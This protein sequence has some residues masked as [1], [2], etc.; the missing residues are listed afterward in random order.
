LTEQDPKQA[1][2][3]DKEA[4]AQPTAPEDSARAD[5]SLDTLLDEY[6]RSVR[7]QTP[8]EIPQQAQ[9]EQAGDPRIARI[10][11]RL[12]QEDVDTAVTNILGD[13]SIPRRAAIGWL[14]QVARERPLVARAFFNKSSDPQTWKKMERSLSHEL[15]KEFKSVMQSRDDVNANVDREA[16]AASLR[17]ASTKVT[18]EPP[19]KFG[20]M[21]NSEF[22]KKVREEY[23]FDPGV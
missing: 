1:V 5:Q 6:D 7:A 22:R 18:A 4:V 9:P 14:D 19:P 13:L 11:Q 23:G 16:V 21:S 2:V 20:N 8:P 15:E 17:G 10:E 3:E 12:L